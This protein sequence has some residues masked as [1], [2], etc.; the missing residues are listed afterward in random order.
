MKNTNHNRVTNQ[1]WVI[2]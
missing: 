1:T 2:S